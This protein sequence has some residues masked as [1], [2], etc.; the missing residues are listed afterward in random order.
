VKST[1]WLSYDLGGSGDYEGMYSWLDNRAPW[2]AAIA[3]RIASSPMK[4]IF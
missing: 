4:A 1:I 3:S 2:N